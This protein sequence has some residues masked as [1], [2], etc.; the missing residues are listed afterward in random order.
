MKKEKPEEFRKILESLIE[1]LT[2]HA[3]KNEEAMNV[4][5][6]AMRILRKISNYKKD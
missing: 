5:L 4:R 1:V 3:G 6:S 2:K